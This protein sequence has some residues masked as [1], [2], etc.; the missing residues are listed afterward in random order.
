VL[1]FI[2]VNS[3]K[4]RHYCTF[5]QSKKNHHIANVRE[6]S[7]LL[8]VFPTTMLLARL[9]PAFTIIIFLF[10]TLTD[11]P[12]QQ[13]LRA[14]QGMFREF[15]EGNNEKENVAQMPLERLRYEFERT[16]DP[17]T[18][19][20][21]ENIKTRELDFAATLPDK[22]PVWNGKSPRTS[23]QSLVWQNIGPNNVGGRTRALAL[24]LDNPAIMLAGS[25]SGGMWRSSDSGTSWVR[26][27][28]ANQIAN[29]TCVAQ[30]PRPNKRRRWY[31]GT[32]EL[33]STTDRRVS[34]Q[35]RTLH[36]G[37]GIFV[38][39]D[40]GASW[41]PLQSTVSG[42]PGANTPGKPNGQLVDF[43]QGV[44]NIA[45]DP[46]RQDSDIVYAACYGGIMRS[47]DG[48]TSWKLTLGDAQTKA[49][50]S[51]VVVTSS[52]VLFAALGTAENGAISPRQGI[53]R[54]VNGLD[55]VKI[56]DV[57]TLPQI[58]RIRL[59][60]APSNPNALYV[61]AESPTVWA[62]RFFSFAARNYFARYTHTAS[63]M[64]TGVWQDRTSTLPRG[65]STLAGYA[66]ALAVHPREENTVAF[67]GTNL[68]V[69]R[70]GGASAE[71]VNTASWR[72][73]GGYPYTQ[74]PTDLHPDVHHV[75]FAQNSPNLCFVASDG[76]VSSS[77][78]SGRSNNF[79]LLTWKPL[80]N[81]FVTSQFYYIAL[82]RL[83][84]GSN[85]VIGGL[86]DNSCF[87]TTTSNPTQAWTWAYGGDGMSC[88][89][90]PKRSGVQ[91]NFIASSQ[92]GYIYEVRVNT[93]GEA[94]P[95]YWWT[96]PDSLD[97][98][99]VFSNFTTLFVTEPSTVKE[100]YVAAQNKLVR[101]NN[102]Q[103]LPQD[104][105]G[106]A[107]DAKW[108][109]MRGVRNVVGTASI[110]ALGISTTSPQHRIFAGTNSGR[111]LRIDRSNEETQTVR[112]V[113][114]SL[115]PRGGFVASIS[116]DA[117]SGNRV[118][119]AFSNYN[120]QSIFAST[121]AGETWTAVSGN[122]EETPDGTGAGP[123]V[124]CVKIVSTGGT[125]RYYAGTS[126]GLFSADTLR[127][128]N[129]EW[130]REGANSLGN[131]MVEHLDARE[132][133]GRVVAGTH[134]N[135]VYAAT[136]GVSEP[137]I[138]TLA[139]NELYPNP[140]KQETTLRLEL[141][142]RQRVSVV[143]YN[144]IGQEVAQILDETLDEGVQMLTLDVSAV[145]LR[146]LATGKYF[147]RVR[148]GERVVTKALMIVRE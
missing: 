32:G 145:P 99:P 111:I 21:P 87:F 141:P 133:D 23:L 108:S 8:T 36:P 136:V 14:L 48:G 92:Y 26:V 116:V 134:G 93:R 80:F 31:Y 132:S 96:L 30:D 144:T 25:V 19:D 9:Y 1:L 88:A 5:L 84:R 78:I 60:V 27:S 110:T 61:F 123:S 117:L 90:L 68:Y 129:T 22:M 137:S 10:G 28:A 74:E 114:S 69:S 47:S 71:R 79:G 75:V 81:G 67:G 16:H 24:D 7:I 46:V 124:R 85:T 54:S 53:W 39:N 45:C 130:R 138:T 38:S 135:G 104:S 107:S 58:R 4:I 91:E 29:V 40:N 101:Y 57:A 6:K 147:C 125:P 42:A 18:G 109:E 3:A 95:N 148:A 126:V 76:G 121:D 56:N 65:L 20:I 72:Q 142:S 15:R 2:V 64:G 82:D 49:W 120:V 119:A 105:A 66:V 83:T 70:D 17:L 139:A 113:T 118:I 12:A 143:L 33:L 41:K 37:N 146:A 77:D 98:Q 131:V 44:W 140:T 63:G 112:E 97:R 73:I 94:I 128:G 62:N 50:C 35:L 100:L 11:S 43:F 13:R 51:D 59:A 34:T 89:V 86:Q 52:G 115:F 103:M 55:W 106:A 102:L 122:L 127:G